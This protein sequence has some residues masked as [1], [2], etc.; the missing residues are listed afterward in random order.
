MAT[1]GTALFPLVPLVPLVFVVGLVEIVGVGDAAATAGV[2]DEE[3][4]A[5]GAALTFAGVGGVVDCARTVT[6]ESRQA[7]TNDVPLIIICPAQR[8]STVAHRSQPAQPLF[9]SE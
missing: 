9:L 7:Q 3:A 5:G 1:A 2:G 8:A 4:V 6:E